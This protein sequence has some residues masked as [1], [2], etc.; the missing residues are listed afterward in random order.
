MA[1]S[2]K[3]AHTTKIQ[4]GVVKAYK[5]WMWTCVNCHH[6]QLSERSMTH[7]ETCR[8]CG[9]MATIQIIGS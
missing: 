5:A 3:A 6:Q 7:I 8:R 2:H 9:K 1:K 4:P